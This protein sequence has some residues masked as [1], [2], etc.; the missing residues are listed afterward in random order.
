[1]VNIIIGMLIWQAIIT[2]LYILGKRD[3][4]IVVVGCGAWFLLIS[5]ITSVIKYFK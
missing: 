1:M 2:L 4:W 5:A 3:R